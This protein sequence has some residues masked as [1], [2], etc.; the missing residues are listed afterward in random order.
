[1]EKEKEILQELHHAIPMVR[2]YLKMMP[3]IEKDINRLKC[4]AKALRNY[5]RKCAEAA[6]KLSEEL[7]KCS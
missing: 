5:H 2:S 6:R 4:E 7:D 3:S 1:M